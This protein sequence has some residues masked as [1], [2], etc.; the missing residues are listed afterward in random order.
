[1]YAWNGPSIVCQPP[2]YSSRIG[3]HKFNGR[4]AAPFRVMRA[5]QIKFANPSIKTFTKTKIMRMNHKKLGSGM[6]SFLSWVF[7]LLFITC[8]NTLIYL[9]SLLDFKESANLIFV[10]SFY[11]IAYMAALFFLSK[12]WQ[13]LHRL[14]APEPLPI[15]KIVVTHEVTFEEL[16]KIKS[17]L[18][19]MRSLKK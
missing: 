8:T 7:I 17:L 2:N 19:E 11:L 3:G 14:L 12:T 9:S 1:M 5:T 6:Q 10:F 15:E 4:F 16:E 18:A 13:C